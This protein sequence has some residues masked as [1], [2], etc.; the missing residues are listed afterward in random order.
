MKKIFIL[1]SFCALVSAIN[2][3][4]IGSGAGGVVHS[5]NVV[6]IDDS[7]PGSYMPYYMAHIADNLRMLK[8]DSI[9]GGYE[10]FYAA[11]IGLNL[12]SNKSDSIA[13]GWWSWYAGHIAN[14]LKLNKTDSSGGGYE[15]YYGAHVALNLKAAKADTTTFIE[16][17]A[18]TQIALNL[19]SNKSDT[20]VIGKMAAYAA[21]QISLNLKCNFSVGD[22]SGSHSLGDVV[23]K[24]S[25]S[26][27]YVYRSTYIH[28]RKWK[29]L[30]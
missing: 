11:H 24:T 28:A 29:A 1:L 16:S 2:G 5:V 22:T 15:P 8:N 25:D 4:I 10:S 7:I 13:G 9:A 19:K 17:K 30:F 14:N 3:Q 21:T 27:A 20:G 26:T 23:F 12:K 6:L 18:A